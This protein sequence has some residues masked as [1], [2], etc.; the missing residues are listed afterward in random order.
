MY[1]LLLI[2]VFPQTLFDRTLSGSLKKVSY[3]V[4]ARCVYVLG[5]CLGSAMC[6][7]LRKNHPQ[8]LHIFP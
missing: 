2:H 4:E 3:K 7:G 1:I 5:H 8:C 6:I